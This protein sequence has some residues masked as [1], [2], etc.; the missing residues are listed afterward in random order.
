MS[1]CLHQSE[2]VFHLGQGVHIGLKKTVQKCRQLFFFNSVDPPG[3]GGSPPRGPL[4]WGEIFL[5]NELRQPE[6]FV[7]GVPALPLGVV[8]RWAGWGGPPFP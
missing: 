6:F 4:A 8:L 7:G 1:K 3:V 5:G 2:K